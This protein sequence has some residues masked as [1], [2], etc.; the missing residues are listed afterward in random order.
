MEM[1][2]LT[3]GV[4]VFAGHTVG[5]QPE[6]SVINNYGLGANSF[7]RKPVKFNENVNARANP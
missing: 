4:S 2:D 6:Y 3:V 5:F 7:I 1:S